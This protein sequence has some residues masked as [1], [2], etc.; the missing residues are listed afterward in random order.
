VR[1]IPNIIYTLGYDRVDTLMWQTKKV[2][3]FISKYPVWDKKYF[4]GTMNLW[5]IGDL[6]RSLGILVFLSEVYESWWNFRKD[7]WSIG[8]N[9]GF[10]V[11]Y[12]PDINFYNF[13]MIRFHSNIASTLEFPI[14]FK[15]IFWFFSFF[16]IL[17][18]VKYNNL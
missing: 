18:G 6:F 10:L 1:F 9:I 8:K 17:L 12:G 15:K 13:K 16:G 3:P 11:L 14:K 4:F 5:R 2:I 7:F